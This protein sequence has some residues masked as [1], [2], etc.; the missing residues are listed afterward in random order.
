[1]AG[2]TKRSV[3]RRGTLESLA[4]ACLTCLS[5]SESRADERIVGSTGILLGSEIPTTS[6][7]RDS[8]LRAKRAGVFGAEVGV[9]SPLGGRT[10]FVLG[11]GA[12]AWA[13]SDVR[14]Q[15]EETVDATV[16]LLSLSPGV[17]MRLGSGGPYVGGGIE[18]GRTLP[19]AI[20]RSP[21]SGHV[22]SGTAEPRSFSV[23]GPRVGVGYRLGPGELFDLGVRAAWLYGAPGDPVLLSVYA[24]A[25]F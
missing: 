5:E 7:V 22:R 17:R 25:C 1:M 14:S 16:F 20:T 3:R 18:V 12:A 15:Q 9:A 21:T 13:W 23:V 11:G 10:S 19:V 8:T 4:L 24:G 6:A 2:A